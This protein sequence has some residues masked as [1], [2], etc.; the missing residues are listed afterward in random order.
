MNDDD[1]RA[2]LRSADPSSGRPPLGDERIRGIVAAAERDSLGGTNSPAPRRR[3]RLFAG[4]SIGAAVTAAAGILIAGLVATPAVQ[5]PGPSEN[6]ASCAPASV[7]SLRDFD[8]V[9]EA[10]ATNVDGGNVTLQVTRVFAGS[11]GRTLTVPQ[12]RD[13]ADPDGAGLF[14]VGDSYL[15]ASADDYISDCDSGPATD[16]LRQLYS[17]AFPSSTNE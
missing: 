10:T 4:A 3:R 12:Q 1:L 7:E 8:T 17:R 2:L 11:P 9:Y 14:L 5:A 13:P 15:I 16:A 6:S